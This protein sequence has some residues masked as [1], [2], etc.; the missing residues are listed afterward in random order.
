ME[1]TMNPTDVLREE[2]SLILKVL[3]AAEKQSNFLHDKKS[4]PEFFQE[5]TDFL[6]NFTDKCH[7][8]KEEG[9]L[10]VNM[11]ANGVP[12]Q[13]GPLGVMLIEHQEGRQYVRKTKAAAEEWKSGNQVAVNE[14]AFNVERYINLL[15][16]HIQKEN[17]MLFPLA[18][19]VI[20]KDKLPAIMEE[21]ERIEKEETG[22]GVHEKYEALA[23]RL[24][25]WGK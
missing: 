19:K 21:F 18:E 25:E 8:A 11:R 2:H 4:S 3:S 15:R 14:L 24:M 17:A 22:E 9:V 7:H 12:E 20:P 1:W 23:D 16:D 10:F 5:L 13:G 6:V